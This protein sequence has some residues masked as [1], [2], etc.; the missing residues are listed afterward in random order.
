M[1]HFPHDVLGQKAEHEVAVLLEQK[2]LSP[3]APVARRVGKVVVAVDLDRDAQLT[4]GE[5]DLRG[6]VAEVERLDEIELEAAS[7]LG[8]VLEQIEQEFLGGAAGGCRGFFGFGS[9]VRRGG[10][11]G[12][13]LSRLLVAAALDELLCNR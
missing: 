10:C 9:G 12:E 3:V 11:A 13:G 7:G 8:Q 4:R 1:K 2:I 5:V 6:T